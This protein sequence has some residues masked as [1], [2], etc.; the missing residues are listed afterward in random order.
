MLLAKRLIRKISSRMLSPH[1]T[2]QQAKAKQYLPIGQYT[3]IPSKNFVLAVSASESVDFFFFFLLASLIQ[4]WFSLFPEICPVI[5]V[6]VLWLVF[7]FL[8]KKSNMSVFQ[9]LTCLL[10]LPFNSASNSPLTKNPHAMICFRCLEA[11][12][13]LVSLMSHRALLLSTAHLLTV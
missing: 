11:G 9:D 10:L 1:Q 12:K 5:C 3:G 4:Q 13:V 8:K 6:P 7:F 2:G